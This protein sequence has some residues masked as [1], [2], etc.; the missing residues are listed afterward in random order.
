MAEGIKTELWQG[1][2]WYG[3]LKGVKDERKEKTTA[4]RSKRVLSGDVG[5]D[6][7]GKKEKKKR[8][9]KTVIRHWRFSSAE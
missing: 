1:K 5:S 6:D 9:S 7:E 8:G 2:R 3:K 4:E